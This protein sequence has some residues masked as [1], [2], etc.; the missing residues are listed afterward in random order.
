MMA[1]RNKF[2]TKGSFGGDRISIL[3]SGAGSR[4]SELVGGWRV[5]EQWARKAVVGGID[6]CQ[7][8]TVEYIQVMCTLSALTSYMELR[9]KSGIWA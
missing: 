2:L 8:L 4:T 3:W 5:V 9:P 1:L 7:Y 6:L